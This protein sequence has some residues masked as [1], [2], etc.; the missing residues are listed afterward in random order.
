MDSFPR[1]PARKI[2]RLDGIWDAAWVGEDCDPCRVDVDAIRY[3]QR[4]AVPGCFDATPRFAG[5]RGCLA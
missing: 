3:D 4:L 2:H 1:Y 5:R